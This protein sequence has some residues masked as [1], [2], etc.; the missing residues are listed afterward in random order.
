MDAIVSCLRHF[1]GIRYELVGF[2][3]MND[4]LHVL[5]NPEMSCRLENIL[6]SWKSYT[7]HELQRNHGRLGAVWQDESFDRIVRNQEELREKMQY[8][9][10]N[11][12]KRWPDQ[13]EY[14]WVWVKGMS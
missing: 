3:L 12:R 7:A 14:R 2:V 5:V 4:H 10:N 1:D 9:V 6:H 8:M 13:N 11:P